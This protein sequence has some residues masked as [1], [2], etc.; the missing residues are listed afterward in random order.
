MLSVLQWNVAWTCFHVIYPFRPHRG[1]ISVCM[2]VCA[3]SGL[4][5]FRNLLRR[6]SL[7]LSFSTH[8]STSCVHTVSLYPS[9]I[10]EWHTTGRP[11][12]KHEH[13][14]AHAFHAG[15]CT[16]Y[17]STRTHMSSER[18]GHFGVAENSFIFT[19]FPVER[20]ITEVW[21]VDGEIQHHDE[22]VIYAGLCTSVLV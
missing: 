7:P 11:T 5:T 10:S 6:V 13:L 15:P 2:C 12:G 21:A 1:N 9:S 18:S 17:I 19:V 20:G 3:L 4:L 22:W 8:Y 16:C 14:H